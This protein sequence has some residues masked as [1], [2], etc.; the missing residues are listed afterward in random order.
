VWFESNIMA[1][2]DEGLA[3]ATSVIGRLPDKPDEKLR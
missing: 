1:V 3:K 2:M